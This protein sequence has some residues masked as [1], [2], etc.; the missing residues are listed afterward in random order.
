VHNVSEC[1]WVRIYLNYI[2][3][4][5]MTIMGS[6]ACII[7]GMSSKHNKHNIKKYYI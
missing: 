3:S 1:V 5:K 4:Y 6:R 2:I 7:M